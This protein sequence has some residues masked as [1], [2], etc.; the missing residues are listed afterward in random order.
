LSYQEIARHG[1]GSNVES[2]QAAE[3]IKPHIY[4]LRRK[5]EPDPS[6]PRYILTVRSVGYMLATDCGAQDA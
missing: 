2:T 3:L 6:E 4:H 1:Q 5:L